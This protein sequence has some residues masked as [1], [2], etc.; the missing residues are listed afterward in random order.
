MN[1]EKSNYIKMLI[2]QC[3]TLKNSVERTLNDTS[4]MESGRFSSFKMYAVQ[5]N[6]LA[7]NVTDVLEIDSRTFVT[8]DVEQMPGWGDSLWPIQRQIV[9]SVLL[10]IGFVLSY[11]EVETDFADDEFTN[12]DNFLK[13]KLRAV[14]FDKPDK[15]ILV[16]NAIE[17]LF[18]GR[19]WIKGID[20]DRECGKFEFSGKEYIPDFIVPKLNLC[21]EVKLLRDGKKSRII[22]E[23][24]ADITAYGKNYERQMFV[25]YDLGVIRD[26]VEFRRDIENAGDDIKVVIVKH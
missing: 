23:I 11:L 9:E 4:T 1:I 3:K 20:Y 5:Y 12:L 7:K 17:N 24:N 16:Q 8:F 14:V 18:V 15:E 2:S 19:G 6:G 26:E 21:I 10:N 22:E 13:T 25:V